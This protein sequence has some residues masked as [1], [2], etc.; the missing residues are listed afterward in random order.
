MITDPEKECVA[1]VP[2]GVGDAVGV[3]SRKW[4]VAIVNHNTEKAV[5]E[6]LEKLGY[7]TYVAKQT[8]VR[9]W[10]NGRKAKVEKVIIPSLVFVKCTQKERHEIV[11]LP[12]IKRFMTDKA[13]VS[14]G[15]VS[16]PL[17]VI[18]Q[19]QIDTLRYMLGQS[20]IP[21][22]FADRPLKFGD[23]V[24][25]ARGSLKGIEGEVIQVTEGKAEIVVRVDMIGVAKMTINASEIEL[26]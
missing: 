15:S 5:Q 6:R 13:G 26:K 1:T 22:S 19:S 14:R 2:S 11:S 21:V 9:I 8:V 23:K 18:P 12:Y 24:V 16:S 3:E 10:K 4:F 25:V 7:E 20:D 17:A